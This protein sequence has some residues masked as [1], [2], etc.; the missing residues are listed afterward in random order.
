V[1]PE[2][3]NQVGPVAFKTIVGIVITGLLGVI[4]YPLKQA[5]KEWVDLKASLAE[6]HAELVQ[7]RTNC[8][9][10]LQSQ[11]DQQIKLLGRV[12]D[13][14]GEIHLSQA[15]MTGYCKANSGIGCSPRPRRRTAKK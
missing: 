12:A 7:Q 6:T 11:G 9:T 14:L 15:E 3:W 2:V 1:N 5:K 13:T 8:L 4:M 10:T